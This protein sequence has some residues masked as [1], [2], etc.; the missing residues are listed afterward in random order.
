[1]RETEID[2][3]K[4]ENRVFRPIFENSTRIYSSRKWANESKWIL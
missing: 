3:Q 4:T 1:M 2:F